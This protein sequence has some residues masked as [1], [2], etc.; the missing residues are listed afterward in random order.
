MYFKKIK[1]K[2][3]CLYSAA[4]MFFLSRSAA[5]QSF[6]SIGSFPA[7][8]GLAGFEAAD[9]GPA[10]LGSAELGPAGSFLFE[11]GRTDFRFFGT[12]FFIMIFQIKPVYIMR[13]LFD[14]S[15]F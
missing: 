2:T 8:R 7:G 3:M 10:G 12:A 6:F 1:P 14:K 4:S 15:S 11:G 5:A 9:L 13:A